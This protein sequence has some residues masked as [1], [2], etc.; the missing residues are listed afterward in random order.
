MC[1]FFKDS[2][3][4]LGK[5]CIFSH[6]PSVNAGPKAKAEPKAPAKAKGKAKATPKKG[7]VGVQVEDIEEPEANEE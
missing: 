7:T 3:C 4:K 5:K 6:G 1:K 2:K